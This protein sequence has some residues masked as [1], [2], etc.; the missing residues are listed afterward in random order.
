MIFPLKVINRKNSKVGQ[1][2][3]KVIKKASLVAAKIEEVSRLESKGHTKNQHNETT[4]RRRKCD[5]E[6]HEIGMAE[7][8]PGNKQNGC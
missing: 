4:K 6:N 5:N 7:I 8:S 3:T 2:S 1:L